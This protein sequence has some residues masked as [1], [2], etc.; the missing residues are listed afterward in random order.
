MVIKDA[1]LFTYKGGGE[2]ISF[3]RVCF[4]Y[5]KVGKVWWVCGH[6]P[7]KTLCLHKAEE[8]LTLHLESARLLERVEICW[9][10]PRWSLAP[11]KRL[12]S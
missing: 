7:M 11:T 8:V 6:Q 9:P 5:P 2:E 4:T 12:A 1:F 10:V 3:V